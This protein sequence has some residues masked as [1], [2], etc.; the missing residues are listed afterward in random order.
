MILGVDIGGTNTDVVLLKNEEF[1]IVGT[2][3]TREFDLSKIDVDYEAV[4]IGI[5]VWLK[6]GKPVGAPNLERIPKIETDKPRIVEND[7]K[8]FAYYCLKTTKKRNIL[9]ITVGTGIG[10][11]LVIE[12][13]LYTGE[14]LAG[15]LGHTYIGGRRKCKCGGYGH[16]EC[17]FSGWAIAD[18]RKKVEDGS[19]YDKK[20]FKVFCKILA[21]A[22]MLLNPEV[23]AL[24]GRIGGKLREEI[25]GKEV[26]TFIPEVFI[27]EFR[28]VNDDFAVA[29]GA[30]MLA[31]DLLKR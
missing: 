4:G 5:A 10:T 11:G 19:I 14:G 2:F 20:G 6:K 21:N 29:K 12:G 9:A 28:I 25:L 26:A 23:V 24:G 27:P 3:K 15:E 31:R 8:C 7:A 13:K 18:V 30:A 22:I 17:Y 1:E 16:L